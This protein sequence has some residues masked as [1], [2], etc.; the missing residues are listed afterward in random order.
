MENKEAL[1]KAIN[2][3]L[4]AHS[5]GKPTEV[6]RNTV[7]ELEYIMD[8]KGP[9]DAMLEFYEDLLKLEGFKVTHARENKFIQI[10]PEVAQLLT[11]F[12]YS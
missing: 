10:F 3:S 2:R 5:L 4:I 12:V 1:M 7:L 9:F 6:N 8:N 11:I